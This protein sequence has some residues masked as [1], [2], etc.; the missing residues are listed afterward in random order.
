MRTSPILL[1]CTALL[2][3]CSSTT[4]TAAPSVVDSR[5]G[6][7]PG[8]PLD[9][10]VVAPL[11]LTTLSPDPIPVTGTDGKIHVAYEIEVLNSG[12][13][14]ATITQIETLAGGPD[15]ATVATVGSQEIAA[16]TI[17]IPNLHSGPVTEIPAGTYCGAGA[18][19]RLRHQRRGPCR[20]DAPD[21]HDA[22]SGSAG[23]PTR[24]LP[25]SR[26]CHADRWRRPHQPG[27]RWSSVRRS[28]ATIGS[29][30]TDAAAS[31]RTVER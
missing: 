10:D 24:Q 17:L 7:P 6:I 22:G 13:K 31:H 27:H 4:D 8:Y 14:P 5:G 28:P 23:V 9:V 18:R 26:C 30:S 21:G 3:A 29:R 25:V 15:G 20:G 12:P 11:V 19:R 1:L 2:V 16:R